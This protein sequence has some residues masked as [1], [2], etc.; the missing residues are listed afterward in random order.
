MKI[1]SID[2]TLVSVPLETP[3]RG[4]SY[5]VDRRSTA[6]VQLTTDDGVVGR[7]YSGD[8]KARLAD[9]GREIE[10]VIAPQ[11]I[12]RDLFSV[13]AV[14]ADLLRGSS[15]Y[16]NRA[17][18]AMYMAAMSAVDTA[19]WDAVGRAL[20]IPLYRLWGGVRSS[21]PVIVIGGYY[22]DGK[23][24]GQLVE[25]VESY[26]ALDTAG[27]KLKVGGLSPAEDLER[28]AAVRDAMGPDFVIAVDANRG[29]DA[30]EAI[31]FARG[32][33]EHDVRWFEE[34]VAWY[35]EGRGMAAVRAASPI[36]VCAGQS[37]MSPHAARRLISTGAVDVVNVDAS[38]CG[39]PTAWRKVAGYAQLMGVE[40]AHHEEVQVAGHLLASMP[41]GTFAEIFH[42]GRDPIVFHM[43]DML[44][45][46]EGHHHLHDRPGL[47]LEYDEDFVARYRV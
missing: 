7:T 10:E 28:L 37:E 36:P 31:E 2:V 4:S 26:H 27:I 29:W 23:T 25:E 18:Q 15:R 20:D 34:P 30:A 45:L 43:T 11:V 32:A 41:N 14:W 3:V 33:V 17:D 44:Q 5:T 40:L 16:A 19:M 46:R 47:G 6:I 12:G 24:L 42:P 9:L 13:E 39:G 22:E 35:D 21:L 8:E 1:R 38:W